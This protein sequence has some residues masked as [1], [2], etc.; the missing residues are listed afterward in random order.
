[1]ELFTDLDETTLE[2]KMETDGLTTKGE[3]SSSNNFHLGK[4][5]T[6]LS[7]MNSISTEITSKNEEAPDCRLP[8]VLYRGTKNV[9][10]TGRVCQKW[11]NQNPH[12]HNYDVF[13]LA[14]E[15]YCRNFD[16]E[17]PWCYTSDPDVRWELC[18]VKVCV[19]PCLNQ[20]FYSFDVIK[21][22]YLDYNQ[23]T[24]CEY[25]FIYYATINNDIVL[26]CSSV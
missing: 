9:T 3:I 10:I 4:D 14:Q 2:R 25:V 20:S 13:S 23:Q 6:T 16:R 12:E 22:C 7:A 8:G 24:D 15:N 18:D 17:E 19:T 5:S 26:P 21:Q 1:M 11:V